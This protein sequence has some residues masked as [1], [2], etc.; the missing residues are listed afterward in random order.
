MERRLHLLLLLSLGR[1]GST[2][3]AKAISESSDYLNAGENRYFWQEL[4]KKPKADHPHE[5]EAFFA[6]KNSQAKYVL[7]KTPHHT[8]TKYWIR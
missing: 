3:L 4:V 7:D 1:S 8:F 6:R 2:F 5:I